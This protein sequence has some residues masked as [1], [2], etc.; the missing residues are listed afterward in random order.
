MVLWALWLLT[1]FFIV[2][3]IIATVSAALMIIPPLAM[4]SSALGIMAE[5]A[6][7]VIGLYIGLRSA[8]SLMKTFDEVEPVPVAAPAEAPA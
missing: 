8:R 7:V 6:V 4:F 3:A 5:A 2:P 1:I